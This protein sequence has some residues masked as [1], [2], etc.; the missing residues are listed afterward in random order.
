M[1]RPGFNN[2]LL[3]LEWMQKLE[4]LFGLWLIFGAL[5]L[6]IP[7]LAFIWSMSAICR[8]HTWWPCSGGCGCPVHLPRGHSQIQL[9]FNWGLVKLCRSWWQPLEPGETCACRAAVSESTT[10]VGLDTP[11]VWKRLL[12]P[13]SGSLWKC[14]LLCLK[15]I[16]GVLSQGQTA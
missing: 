1:T 3:S 7:E 15:T 10:K 16:A 4:C 13:E 2:F 6:L 14:C 12:M 8:V 9:D 11:K 5:L